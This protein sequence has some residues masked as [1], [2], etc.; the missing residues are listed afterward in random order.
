MWEECSYVAE[1]WSRG[2][3]ISCYV[4]VFFCVKYVAIMVVKILGDLRLS[5]WEGF[6]K[7]VIVGIV[8]VRTV[9]AKTVFERRCLS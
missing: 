9:I 4:Y 8:I 2:V 5:W 3:A 6:M 1:E 7:T